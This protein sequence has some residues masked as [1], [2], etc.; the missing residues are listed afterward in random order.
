MHLESWNHIVAM[1][2]HSYCISYI[3]VGLAADDFTVHV[4]LEGLAPLKFFLKK[5]LHTYVYSDRLHVH[6]L[7]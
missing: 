4:L 7:Q 6:V 3:D 5:T 1:E 2:D